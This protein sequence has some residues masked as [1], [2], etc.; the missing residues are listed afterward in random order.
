MAA[1]SSGLPLNIVG[2]GALSLASLGHG[3]RSEHIK[4]HRMSEMEGTCKI[5]SPAVPE[6]ESLLRHLLLVVIYR[7]SQYA[8]WT[9]LRFSKMSGLKN[10]KNASHGVR[11]ALEPW[12]CCP[13]FDSG[14]ARLKLSIKQRN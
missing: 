13:L 6:Q 14:E 8:H 9:G 3:G 12:L 11:R 5:S 7:Q 1:R 10:G 2:K 4:F